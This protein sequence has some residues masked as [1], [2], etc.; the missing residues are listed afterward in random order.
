M[1]IELGLVELPPLVVV[2]LL[3]HPLRGF[4]T[5]TPPFGAVHPIRPSDTSLIRVQSRSLAVQS[6]LVAAVPRQAITT[7]PFQHSLTPRKLPNAMAMAGGHH[8]H[9]GGVSPAIL[10]PVLRSPIPSP[11]DKDVIP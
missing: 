8:D 11:L 5:G 10:A 7:V 2:D 1:A 9:P 3:R 6:P 4:M